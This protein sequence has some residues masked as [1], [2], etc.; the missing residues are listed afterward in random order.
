MP[1]SSD[2]IVNYDPD[3]GRCDDCGSEEGRR[4][5]TLVGAVVGDEMRRIVAWLCA[6]CR[7]KR[8]AEQVE[9]E[10]VEAWLEDRAIDAAEEADR[11]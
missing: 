6:S 11:A 2:V 5:R 10:K 3:I 7:G 9:D 4:H 1:D 8:L